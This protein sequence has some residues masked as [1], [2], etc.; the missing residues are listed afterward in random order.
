MNEHA[1][2]LAAGR[3]QTVFY[4]LFVLAREEAVFETDI[5]VI[6]RQA[7]IN[8]NRREESIGVNPGLVERALPG[9][10]LELF[11][12][13]IETCAAF[14]RA[15][16][17]IGESGEYLAE[18]IQL[19][20]MIYSNPELIQA[21]DSTKMMLHMMRMSGMKNPTQMLRS[22]WRVQFIPDEQVL[23]AAANGSIVPMGSGGGEA[24][25][26]ASANAPMMAGPGQ[27]LSGRF[28]DVLER[29]TNG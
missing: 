11:F 24:S 22:E 20:G 7:R 17:N 9:V 8:R 21:F 1:D 15:L 5:D 6:P 27:Q 10:K 13:R 2:C 18:T 4:R 23:E 26:G 14:V 29:A 3:A 16:D 28:S 25:D 19:N 12:P